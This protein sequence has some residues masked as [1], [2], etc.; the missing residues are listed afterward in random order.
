MG[1]L[2]VKRKLQIDQR[3]VLAAA[4]RQGRADAVERFGGT[5]LRRIHKRRHLLARLGLAQAFLHQ[6]MARELLVE[7]LVDRGGLV[8]ILVAREPAR[9]RLGDAQ[10]GIV[11]LVGPLEARAGVLF[12]ARQLEDHARMQILEDR[13]PF[14][15]G[16]LVDAGDRAFGVTGAVGRPGRQQRRHQIGDRA[17][18][19][20]VDVELGGGIFFLL[21]AVH[22]DHE[23]RDAVR[24]VVR[25]DPLGELDGLVDVAIRDRRDEGAVQELVVL[26]IGA[27]GG[28]I[29]LR[30]GRRI[31]FH[32]RMARGEIAAGGRERLQ[33]VA[34]RKLR[35][36]HRRGIRTFGRLRRNRARHRHRGQREGGNSPASATNGKHHG[37]L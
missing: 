18:D 20:L 5:G 1:R 11:E 12:L 37:L 13:I 30:S 35:H 6:R 10:H 25:Q 28:A 34:G 14:R 17:A 21:Q 26:G 9:I 22:A 32:A 4:A 7:G 23:P 24:L 8:F 3:E 16:Q 31:T 29:E 19:G 15:T 27:Q 2:E 36:G 33:I